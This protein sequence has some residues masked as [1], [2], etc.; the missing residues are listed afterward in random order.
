MET[1]ELVFNAM[2]KSGKSLKAGEIAD[3]TGIDKK[4]VD[5]AMKSL[6]KEEKIFSP[7]KCYYS[8]K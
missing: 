8:P 4:E 5:K 2:K 3:M 7:K 6:L 1:K